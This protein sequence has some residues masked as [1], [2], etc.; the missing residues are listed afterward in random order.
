[1]NS[2]AAG[3]GGVA[4]GRAS[5]VRSAEQH[6][7]SVKWSLERLSEGGELRMLD[8]ATFLSSLPATQ[9]RSSQT[10]AA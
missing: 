5:K 9:A 6:R 7:L 2:E 10:S 4:A 1:M 3:S 8:N